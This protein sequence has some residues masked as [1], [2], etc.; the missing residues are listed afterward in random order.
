MTLNTFHHA[1]VGAKNVTL[2]VPRLR[3]IINVAKTIKTPQLVVYLKGEAGRNIERAKAVQSQ[4]EHATFRKLVSMSEI[5]Y[6]PDLRKTVRESDESMI[7]LFLD[8][9]DPRLHLPWAI[10]FV[11]DPRMLV[12]KGLHLS[13]VAEMIKAKY[14]EAICMYSDEN[15]DEVVFRVHWTVRPGCAARLPRTCAPVGVLSGSIGAGGERVLP[16]ACDGRCV[17]GA[18]VRQD[19]TEGKVDSSSGRTEQIFR[20]LEAALLNMSVAGFDGI[21]MVRPSVVLRLSGGRLRA[22]SS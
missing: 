16:A 13:G 6:D 22:S 1:G 2:G 10:R 12:D 21:R 17:F 7:R 18:C 4:L 11:I 8:G 20:T 15:E 5:L 3:E 9:Y 14:P 19:D